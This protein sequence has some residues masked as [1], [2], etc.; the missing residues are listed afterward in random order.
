MLPNDIHRL[1]SGAAQWPTKMGLTCCERSKKKEEKK[2][3]RKDFRAL[4]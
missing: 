1:T 4:T 3:K 2:E